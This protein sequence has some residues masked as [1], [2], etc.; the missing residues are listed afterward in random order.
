MKPRPTPPYQPKAFYH[1]TRDGRLACLRCKETIERHEMG[2]H[3][4]VCWPETRPT[5]NESCYNRPYERD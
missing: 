5:N 3:T 2:Q 1:A 4:A